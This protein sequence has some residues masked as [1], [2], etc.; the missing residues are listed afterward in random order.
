MRKTFF[1]AAI[2]FLTTALSAFAFI[3]EETQSFPVTVNYNLTVSEAISA[4]KYYWSNP[5]VSSKNFPSDQKGIVKVVIELVHFDQD[6]NVDVPAELDKRGL[7]P[8]TLPEL[9]AFGARYPNKQRE[10]PIV[11]LGSTWRN[12]GLRHVGLLLGNADDRELTLYWFEA[13][14]WAEYRIAAIRK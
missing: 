9:L 13:C 6:T 11:A 7:R 8:A 14:C 2:L 3:E 1:V 4:G 5:D 12:N 10:F